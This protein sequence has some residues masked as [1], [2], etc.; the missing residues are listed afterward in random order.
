[1]RGKWGNGRSFVTTLSIFEG[2]LGFGF[3][4]F[5]LAMVDAWEGDRSTSLLARLLWVRLTP[6]DL[7]VHSSLFDV[8]CLEGKKQSKSCGV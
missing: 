2:D 5:W 1:M 4:P 7:E 8:V 3:C 6:C